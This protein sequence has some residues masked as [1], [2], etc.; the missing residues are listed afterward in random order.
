MT[1]FAF[2]FD[3]RLGIELPR[4]SGE[5]D[6]LPAEERARILLRWEEIR[7]RIPDRIK[8]LER[9]IMAKQA[10]LDAEEDFRRSC[11]LNSE[12]ADLASVI[13]D[14]HIWYRTGQDMEDGKA[15]R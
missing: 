8:E 11:A 10:Q 7:G 13:N 2:E 1:T 14:L 12:I 5:W 15:H 9:A 4:M 6:D 3:P